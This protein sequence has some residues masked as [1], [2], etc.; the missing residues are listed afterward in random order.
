MFV[1]TIVSHKGLVTLTWTL[2]LLSSLVMITS[3]AWPSLTSLAD[4]MTAGT[5]P[6]L[7]LEHKV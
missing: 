7:N 2:P 4:L 5:E 1:V 3:W 6:R